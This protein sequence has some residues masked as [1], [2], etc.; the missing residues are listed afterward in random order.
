V[1]TSPSGTALTGGVAGFSTMVSNA[2]GPVMQIFFVATGMPKD[3]LMGTTALYFFIF[4]LAKLPLMLWLTLDNPKAPMM[5]W[6]TF[7]FNLWMAPLIVAGAL[8]GKAILPIIP[9]KQFNDA[10]LV[11][12]AV[13][14][15]K[16][17]F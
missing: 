14:A 3:A 8:L 1:P 15:V 13:A 4:N 2:A 12:T 7:Q 10:V 9:Q 17:L 5:N 6:P 11:L 16:L